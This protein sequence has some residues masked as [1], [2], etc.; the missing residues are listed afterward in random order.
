MNNWQ[1]FVIDQVIG[2]ITGPFIWTPIVIVT[3]ALPAPF[4]ALKL[5]R[6]NRCQGGDIY[7]GRAQADR[8]ME[9]WHADSALASID[10]TH[11]NAFV[12]NGNPQA[13]HISRIDR[14][15]EKSKL[16]QLFERRHPST[17]DTQLVAVR[18]TGLYYGPRNS[19]VYLLLL[20]LR[21]SIFGDPF[22]QIVGGSSR[23]TDRDL[24]HFFW[25]ILALFALIYVLVQ[26]FLFQI[27]EHI[28]KLI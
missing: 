2:A 6:R 7:R 26:A 21:V 15:L 25:E 4:I 3:F 19:A 24:Q 27:F 12:T 28:N 9:I 22:N 10:Q 5:I 14:E 20:F 23:Y 17:G 1:T 11:H 18:K 8:F 13:A 16:I